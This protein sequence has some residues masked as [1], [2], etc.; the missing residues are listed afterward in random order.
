MRSGPEAASRL[1]EPLFQPAAFRK[2]LTLAAP[3]AAAYLVVVLGLLVEF[4]IVGKELGGLG[5]GALGLAGTMSLVL[6]LSFHAIEIAAQAII[7]RRHGEGN[8]AA[9]GKCLD[10]ALMLG[11]GL[12]VPLTVGLYFLGPRLLGTE[13]PEIE[14]LAVEYFRWRLPS[15]PF[16]IGALAVIGFFNGIGRPKIPMFVYALILSL[17]AILC[18]GLVRG[19]FG[20]PHLGI[21]GA[22][23]AQSISTFCGFSTFV[24]VLLRDR[25]RGKH[26]CLHFA[27]NF[28]WELLRSLAK[29]SAPVFVQQF[30]ANVGVF[31]AS[32]IAAM[33]PDQGVGLSALTIA[34]QIGYLTYL[35][36]L[37]FGIAAATLVGQSLGAGNIDRA[38]KDGYRCWIAGA[39]FMVTVGGLFMLLRHPLVDQF[40]HSRASTAASGAA[41]PARVRELAASLLLVVGGYQLLESANT[42]LGKALQGAGATFY[43]M[44]VSIIGQWV[45]FLPLAWWLALPMG[46]GAFGPLM[47]FA[48]QVGFTGTCFLIKF[49]KQGW[50][51][52]SV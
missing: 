1:N 5:I 49:S 34:R 19:R 23:L 10:N 21:R 43:V 25:Y 32:K 44:V 28:D 29:L 47:A 4:M 24:I 3:I 41:D 6:V 31:L 39:T 15:I 7:A 52:K 26:H 12:G 51:R 2:V 45:L 11:F 17:N 27:A 13:N 9:T 36:S 38:R 16:F 46:L 18:Q 14:R 42:I 35:P 40:L 50:T 20:L 33:L 8:D 48:A 22:G 30:F 37:G